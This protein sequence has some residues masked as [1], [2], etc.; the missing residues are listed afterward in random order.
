MNK[1]EKHAILEARK[2][3]AWKIMLRELSKRV[4]DAKN[5]DNIDAE[6]M[7][8]EV[9]ARKRA[10]AIVEEWVEDIIGGLDEAVIPLDE[11]DD[12][13]IRAAEVK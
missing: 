13:F 6:D 2:T 12:V 1:L 11:D 5:I 7:H 10:A 3:H 9:L 8:L 4:M